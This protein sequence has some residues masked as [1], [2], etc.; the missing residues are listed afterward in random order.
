MAATV[1][2]L[3][4]TSWQSAFWGSVGAPLSSLRQEKSTRVAATVEHSDDSEGDKTDGK[5]GQDEENGGG[6]KELWD[7]VQSG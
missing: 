2:L 7:S 6:L 5:D 4:G 1:L 3:S